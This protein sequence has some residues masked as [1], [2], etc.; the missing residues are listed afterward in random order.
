[1]LIT[2]CFLPFL[3]IQAV[4]AQDGILPSFNVDPNGITVSGFSAGAYFATQFHVAFSK[5]VRGV[6][7]W[8]GGPPLCGIDEFCV[9]SPGLIDTENLV[10][11]A[12]E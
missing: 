3:L 6:G 11:R 10:A 5:L 8:S 4:S 7:I 9:D 12:Q 2:T 1:M